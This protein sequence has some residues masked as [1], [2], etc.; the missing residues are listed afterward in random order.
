MRKKK[1]NK[2]N[3][4]GQAVLEGVMMRGARSMAVAVRDEDGVIRVETERIKDVKEKP[5]VYRAPFIRGVLSLVFS[6]FTGT[7][8]L[9]RSAEVYGEGEPSKL[10]KFL[11][12]KLKIDVYNVVMFLGV[13]IG[14]GLAIAL[15]MILP[16]LAVNGISALTGLDKKG[17]LF[18]LIEGVIKIGVFVLYILLTSLMKDIRRTFMYH[19][20]EHKT[21]SCYEMGLPLTVENVKKC[22]RVHDRCGTTFTFFVL[23]VSVL[24]FSVV[25]Y[26][27]GATSVLQRALVKIAL[28]PVV[29]GISYEILKLLAKTENP[30]FFIFKAPGLALQML[31]TKEPDDKMIEVAIKSFTTVLEMDADE[32]IKPKKFVTAEKCKNAVN[33]VIGELNAAGIDERAEGEWLVSIVTGKPRSEVLTSDDMLSP[34]TVEKINVALEERKSGR[35]LW[36]VLGSCDFYGFEF[37]TDERAL[38]PRPETEE[39]VFSALEHVRADSEVLDL[40]TGSGAI[41]ITIALKTG[42]TVTASDVS[43]SALSLARENAD[44]LGANVKFVKSDMFDEIDGKFDVIVSNPPYIPTGDIAGL[45]KELSFEPMI[46]LDGGDDGLKYYRVIESVAKSYLKEN[47]VLLLE[48]GIGEKDALIDLFAGFSSVEVKKDASGTDRILIAAK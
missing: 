2:T 22:T 40:C 14:L 23:F 11:S 12:E 41:A 44:A 16:N 3:I 47:G 10:E 42:A 5:F 31:T 36:Y 28:L 9:M 25:N 43:E 46:A 29:A 20:A 4:G 35:P 19:G 6:L 32:T 7:K 48:F 8:I 17:F 39:L 33:R 21:I 30:V 24:V 1:P 37:R 34:S 26:F 27:L 18:N 13:A 15:F 45:Q 38:I